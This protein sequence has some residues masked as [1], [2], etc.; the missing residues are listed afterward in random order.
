MKA[1]NYLI[2]VLAGLSF[3]TCNKDY[4]QTCNENKIAY[5]TSV[6][7]PGSGT[8][9]EPILIDVNFGVTN[10][11]GQFGKFIVSTDSSN[12][13]TIETEAKYVGCVC[14]Q[15]AP[16]RSAQYKFLTD[17]PGNYLIKFRSGEAK[18]IIINLEILG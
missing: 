16:I 4:P 11:C 7:Y 17:T 10:G 6:K 12:T 14:T 15:D 9:N 8:V 1:G 5:V 2:L 3:I 13:R 18:F